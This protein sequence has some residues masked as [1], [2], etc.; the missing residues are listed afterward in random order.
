M[1]SADY[2]YATVEF[3]LTAGQLTCPVVHY[4]DPAPLR[5]RNTT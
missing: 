5:P 3:Q 1:L 2:Q 4:R